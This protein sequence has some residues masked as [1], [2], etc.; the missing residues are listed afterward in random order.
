MEFG[1]TV[2]AA[3]NRCPRSAAT[4]LRF[5]AHTDDDKEDKNDETGEDVT[6]WAAPVG[7]GPV[8]LRPPR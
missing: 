7:S 4:A 2:C 8:S 3:A 6:H 1:Q 5:D